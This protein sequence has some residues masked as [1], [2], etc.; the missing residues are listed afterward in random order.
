AGIGP[1]AL[2]E[3]TTMPAQSAQ[4]APAALVMVRRARP[5][6]LPAMMELLNH[7]ARQGLLLPRS[8]E[9]VQR[10]LGDFMVAVDAGGV[11]GCAGLRCYSAQLAEVVGVAVD[12]RYHG[13]GVGRHLIEA[14]LAEARGLGLR[15]VF[16]LTL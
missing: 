6:D 7:Y 16:A 11:V 4:A 13:Q 1:V 15:R 3:T 10:Q 12:E 8:P 14:L 5:A 9:Q 2:Q